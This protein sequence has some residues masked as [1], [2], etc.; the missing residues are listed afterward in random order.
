MQ[1]KEV[2]RAQLEAHWGEGSWFYQV[3]GQPAREIVEKAYGLRQCSARQRALS[4]ES[5]DLVVSVFARRIGAEKTHI[6]HALLSGSLNSLMDAL[7]RRAHVRHINDTFL[8]EEWQN[9]FRE[10]TSG[11][12]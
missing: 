12:L 2:Q 11:T 1:F 7:G 9:A 3:L 4:Q 5:L 10:V 8:A 6:V